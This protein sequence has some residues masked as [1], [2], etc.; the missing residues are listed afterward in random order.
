MSSELVPQHKK[1]A[2]G[3]SMDEGTFGVGSLKSHM[4]EAH[5]DPGGIKNVHLPENGRAHT[6]HH[7]RKSPSSMPAD[8]D[9]GPMTWMGGQ[10]KV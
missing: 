8:V 9:H 5:P 4:G 2:M 6:G 7:R 10:A 3:Q 1:L